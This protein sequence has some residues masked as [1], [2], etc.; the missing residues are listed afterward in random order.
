MPPQITKETFAE[1]LRDLG[2][3]PSNYSGK[4]LSLNGMSDL[5]GINPDSILD[6]IDRR[7]LS[8]HYDYNND[9]I[10]IDAL[11]AAH[12]FYCVRAEGPL[13]AE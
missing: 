1:A 11:D 8:A 7:H 9:T 4:K 2:H 12:F 10:W 3:D 5:Y 6:A 13:Y